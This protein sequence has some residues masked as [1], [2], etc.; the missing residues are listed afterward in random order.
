MQLMPAR[1]HLEQFSAAMAPMTQR[2]TTKA[3]HH[4]AIG[5][6]LALGCLPWLQGCETAQALAQRSTAAA[7]APRA[8]AGRMPVASNANN[9]NNVAPRA[10]PA[11]QPRRYELG[12]AKLVDESEPGEIKSIPH[13]VTFGEPRPIPLQVLRP[14]TGYGARPIEVAL[15]GL[16]SKPAYLKCSYTLQDTSRKRTT[17]NIDRWVKFWHGQRPYVAG[18]PPD[19]LG[20]QGASVSE[21]L[22]EMLIADVAV[23]NCPATWG[24]ALSLAM[25]DDVWPR[26]KTRPMPVMK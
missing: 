6:G 23:D 3:F 8:P 22:A 12:L 10:I 15:P 4:R 1:P 13:D 7:V 11:N 20:G 5:L 17:L 21:A 24:E 19:R 18:L 14:G 16:E 9:A 25:G 26:V 2:N